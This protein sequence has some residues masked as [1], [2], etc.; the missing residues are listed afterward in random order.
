MIRCFIAVQ[1]PPAVIQYLKLISTQLRG[2]DLQGRFVPPESV[3]LTLKFLG[4]IEESRV[5][6]L[7]ERIEQ[8]CQQ[9]QAFELEAGSLGVFPHSKR[10]RVAWVGLGASRELSELHRCTEGSLAQEGF[11]PDKRPFHPHLTLL[12]LKSQ[13]NVARLASLINRTERQSLKFRVE[14]VHLFQ[15]L[16]H[17]DGARHL[18]LATSQLRMK[19]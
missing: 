4:N 14:E 17:P 1:L 7:G 16:L 15:S 6:R 8:C 11:E 13:R 3:H 18:K 9:S 19:E 5:D 2:L 10:P 12:R